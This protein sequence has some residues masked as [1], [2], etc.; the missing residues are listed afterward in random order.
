MA[1]LIRQFHNCDQN[2]VLTFSFKSVSRHCFND[3]LTYLIYH[4][5]ISDLP[6]SNFCRMSVLVPTIIMLLYLYFPMFNLEAQF[7]EV[8]IPT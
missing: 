8:S 5:S 7:F 2:Y 3:I 1:P 4:L 6:S